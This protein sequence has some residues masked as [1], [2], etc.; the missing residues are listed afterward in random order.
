MC[1]DS[2][3]RRLKHAPVLLLCALYAVP[4]GA[5]KQPIEIDS[6]LYR[7]P[8]TAFKRVPVFLEA[9]ADPAS[10]A[11]LPGADL[12]TQSVAF[13]LREL[14][15]GDETRLAEADSSIWW[16]SL[17]GEVTVTVDRRAPLTW[18]VAEW[19]AGADTLPRSALAALRKAIEAVAASGE[20]IPLPEGKE[21]SWTFGM[22]LT[23][24]LVTKQGKLIPVKG[25]QPV[26]VFTLLVPWEQ[27]VEMIRL[28]QLE[29]SEFAKRL[30][31]TGSVRL[32]FTVDKS[33]RADPESVKEIFLAGEKRPVGEDRVYADSFIRAVK[34]ALPSAK[35]APANI[36]GCAL[37][38]VVQQVFDFR[39]GRN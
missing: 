35:F 36:G 16:A 3:A 1:T 30:G 10:R 12:F 2:I 34:R 17:W 29:Y 18:R 7:I 20:S 39:W 28:P 24:P 38:Q 11:I 15:G 13:K 27:P 4:A 33:G 22:S 23:N 5:Q 8:A 26:P 21:T 9:T 37:N 19:S 32:S 14:V 31:A 25:R 6:C